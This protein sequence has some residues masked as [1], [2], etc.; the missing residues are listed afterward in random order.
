MSESSFDNY[1]AELSAA[2]QRA[3][4]FDDGPLLLLA[5][6][7]SGKTRVLTARLCRL[8]QSSPGKKFRVLALTFTNAAASEMRERVELIS[9]E[10]SGRSFVGTF[11]SFCADLLRQHGSHVQIRPDFTVLTEEE[12]RARVFRRSLTKETNVLDRVHEWEGQNTRILPLIDRVKAK[13]VHTNDISQQFADHE[14]GQVVADSCLLYESGMRETNSL[15]FPSIL[16]QAFEL[17]TRHTTISRLIRTTYK[18]W[19]IDEFQDTNEI[20]YKILLA[21]AGN[22]FRNLFVVADEDQIIYQWNGASYKRI[23]QL[24]TDFEPD[25]LQLPKNFRCPEEIVTL[26]NNLIEHN[27]LRNADK[28]RI[29]ASKSHENGNYGDAVEIYSYETDQDEATGIASLAAGFSGQDCSIAILGRNRFI[30]QMIQGEL[31]EENVA[32]RIVQ[33]RTDFL[34]KTYSLGYRLLRL[35]VRSLDEDLLERCAEGV[36]Q[37]TGAS[38]NAESVVARARSQKIDFFLALIREIERLGGEAGDNAANWASLLTSLNEREFGPDK[39]MNQLAV[40]L[41]EHEKEASTDLLE[42]SEAWRILDR[43]I[44]MALGAKPPLNRYLQELDMRSKEPPLRSGEIALMTI[45]SSK[46]MEFD[47]VFL[48]GLAEEV[49]PSWQSLKAN[50]SS[51]ELEEERRNCFVAITRARKKLVLT[52]ATSYRGWRKRP[53]RFLNEM[54]EV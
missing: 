34:S 24:V 40:L 15:D 39:F 2:Q 16:A 46:G 48:A 4:D 32:S 20:Q 35:S 49:L 51:Q 12:E 31:V 38:I 19:S 42:D 9:P 14:L 8:L 54:L 22:N 27:S 25:V 7:G 28:R 45:H 23:E 52:Y 50:A 37:L 33:R 11:H 1:Y 17:I 29:E 43:D 53:S 6:P 36:A 44:R 41:E 26:A 10:A 30:L 21:L 13:G 47:V 5:G 18:Y 3:A